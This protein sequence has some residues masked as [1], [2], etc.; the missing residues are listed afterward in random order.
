[1]LLKYS[2]NSASATFTVNDNP[3][4]PL[5][6]ITRSASNVVLSWSTNAQSFFLQSKADLSPGSVW[7]DV[8]NTPA[9]VG[10]QW[11][12]TNSISA[13]A[14]FYRL[15]QRLPVL[16]ATMPSSNRVVVSWPVTAAGGVLKT[17]TNL[18]SSSVWIVVSNPPPVIVGDRYYVTN[19]NSGARRFY[20]LYN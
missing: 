13:A 12:V 2:N 7:T 4:L 14:K 19:L 10:N 6:K 18:Q 16:S 11:M 5:L 9:R 8:T 20:R 1:M 17:T 3:T 15:S